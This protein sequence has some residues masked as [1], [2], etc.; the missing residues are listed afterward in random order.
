MRFRLTLSLLLLTIVTNSYSASD[1]LAVRELRSFDSLR[2]EQYQSDSDFD[3]VTK[4]A[5]IN[6]W[7]GF[8]E[9][10]ISIIRNLFEEEDAVAIGQIVY[11]VIRVLLWA[12][13]IFSIG[14][15]I[16]SLYKKG[17]FGLIGRKQQE[18][19]IS[20]EDLLFIQKEEDWEERI[21]ES[22]DECNYNE[23]IRF[24][25]LQVLRILDDTNHIELDKA[26]SIRDYQKELS[27]TYS[28][29]FKVLSR[30]YQYAW[31]G[32]VGI[33]KEHFNEMHSTFRDFNVATNVE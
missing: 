7:K 32:G 21:R 1:T 24:L 18:V 9:W 13:A 12:L 28:N 16:Y 6:W 11:V 3:Y 19:N 33:D 14:I 15:V 26:K 20:D 27:N 29:Q 4:P 23:A 2:L 17:V 10:V 25:F 8:S 31:F 22:I 30:Y 5:E